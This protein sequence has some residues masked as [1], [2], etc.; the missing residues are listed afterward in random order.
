V[1][2][3]NGVFLSV[4]AIRTMLEHDTA[5]APPVKDLSKS[6]RR[7]L[8]VLVEKAF[9]TPDAY[10]LTLKAVTTGCN[11]KNNRDPVTNY[12]EDDVRETLDQLRE[13]K[14][15]AELHTESGRTERYRHYMRHRFT[16][17]EP[18]LAILT[19]LLL[20]GRQ[21]LGELRSRASRMV[22]IE[23]LEQL[24]S[25]L[26]GLLKMGLIQTNGPPERRGAEVDHNLYRANEGKILERG[27]AEDEPSAA[28]P[29]AVQR[30][31]PVPPQQ[32][33]IEQLR[34]ANDELRRE[35]QSVRETVERLSDDF[36]RLRR[37][38]GG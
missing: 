9:T 8:G 18:Q 24:R 10:P 20:R 15:I 16:M 35:L 26:E 7:V 19:E 38:C 33:E 5:S 11:Q 29:A 1:C 2:V 30:V 32:T 14:L 37:E 22:P 28:R 12:S 3:E 31:T 4:R 36:E 27:L 17:T 34:L 13:L 25:E 21:Q 6:Q 23:T